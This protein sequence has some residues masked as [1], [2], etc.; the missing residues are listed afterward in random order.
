MANNNP[1]TRPSS[2]GERLTVR[3]DEGEL[4]RVRRRSLAMRVAPSA[5]VRAAVL[6]AVEGSGVPTAIA[7]AIVQ[8][9]RFDADA[10]IPRE[11][12]TELNRV[13]VNVNQIARKANSEGAAAVDNPDALRVLIELADVLRRIEDAIGGNRRA[14]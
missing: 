14:A 12:R 9:E 5:L 3:F 8:T 13:G 10:S 6:D 11:L 4:A 2:K 7:G 1:D